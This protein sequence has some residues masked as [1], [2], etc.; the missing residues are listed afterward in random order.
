MYVPLSSGRPKSVIDDYAL[1][2][3]EGFPPG[4][5]ARRAADALG[6]VTMREVPRTRD[7]L[8]LR[9][10]GTGAVLGEAIAELLRLPGDAWERETVLSE[11]VALR[12]DLRDDS[13][14]EEERD[15][16]MTTS[17]L[18]EHWKQHYL[19]EG[20]KEMLLTAYRS[21]FG[22]PPQEVSAAIEGIHDT[23]T[24]RRW[25]ALVVSASRDEVAAAVRAGPP[26]S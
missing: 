19:D 14:D 5:Y 20:A 9:L 22:D 12:I 25:M 24:L 8:L 15:F 6:V 7:T 23:A 11:L 13:S 3:M 18:Y 17:A 26:A 4:F 1:A 21:R 2:P 16:I 10:L